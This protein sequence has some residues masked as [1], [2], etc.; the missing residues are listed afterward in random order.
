[1]AF[2]L[3]A[4]AI[5]AT[6][7][8]YAA[9]DLVLTF[10]KVGSTSTVYAD[11]GSAASFRGASAGTFAAD[12]INFLD[13][14][15]TLTSAFGADW[16]S[17]P[18]VFSSVSA[19]YSSSGTSNTVVDGDAS[20]TLYVS[21]TRNDIGTAGQAN[22]GTPSV[23]SNT[24]MTGA[25]SQILA[26]NAILGSN[27][28]GFGQT[29]SDTSVSLID[30]K[31]PIT[32][33][34]GSNIQGTAFG[35]FGG[36][37]AQAGSASNFG[38]LG[39]VS[40]VEFALDLY[41][42][43]AVNGKTNEVNGT[44]RSGDFQGTITLNSS[45]QVSFLGGATAPAVT[46]QPSAVTL[47]YG[48]TTTLS[49]VAT[50]N[51]LTYQWY[52]GASGDTSSPIAGAT[53]ASYTTS[54]LTAASNNFWVQATNALGTVDSNTAT[55]N[56]RPVLTGDL[57]LT[58]QKVGSTKTVYADLGSASSFRGTAN[59][60]NIADL[61]AVL[62]EAFGADWAIDPNVFSSVSGVYSSSGTSNT[63]V[64]GD[65]SRTLYVSANRNDV[66]SA[67]IANSG[68]P[69]V[70]SNTDMTGAASQILAQN[71]I[72]G[73]NYDVL[74]T[75][76]DTSISLIDDKQ[77]ITVFGGSNIQGTAFG[78]FGGGISQA[79]NAS[80]FGTLGVAGSVEFALD[81]YRI[82]AVNGKI[83]EVN[84]T[85]RSGDFQGTV[86]VD[87]SGIV[88]FIAAVVA[89]AVTAQPTAVTLNYSH[90]TTLS[91]AATGDSLTYQWYIGT[92]GDTSSPI[93]DAT[94]ASYTTSA[95]TA[96]TSFWVRT[97]NVAGSVDS[98]TATV[99]VRAPLTGDLMLTFQKVGSTKTV[100]ADLGSAS[101]F[102]GAANT[103][104]I[105]D[106][107]AVLIEAFG[108]DWASDPNVFSSV[109]GV[110]SSSSTSSTVVNGDASRTLYV[111]ATRND[112]GTAGQANS[113]TPTVGSNTDMT[114]AASQILAQ[115]AI[116]GSNY[117]VL[118]TVSDTSISLIDDKQPITVFGGSNIQGTAFGVFG[119]GIAQAGS[120]SS[121][122][123]LG[124]A[125]N[126]EFALDLYRIVAVNGK[127][128]EIN[129]TIR[130]GDF[131][132]TVT[133]NSSGIVSFVAAVAAPTDVIPAITTQPSSATINNGATTTL[134][135]EASG[136]SP[137]YQWYTGTS[138]DTTSPIGGATSASYTTSALTATTS[139]WVRA[140]NAA[141]DADSSAATVTVRSPY[142]SWMTAYPSIS[143]SASADP[144]KD[145]LSNLTE[146]AL[147][148]NPSVAGAS[149][150]PTAVISGSNLVVSFNRSADS[151]STTTAVVQYSTNLNTWT[152]VSTPTTGGA[153]TVNVPKSN[154]VSGKLFTRLKV[155]QP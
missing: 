87:N 75:V 143:Q 109:S 83:N 40:S 132:G 77:P 149:I 29:V 32:V 124:V 120:A 27:Y 57:M 150:A 125:S 78:V 152:D 151:V 67:G 37:I 155:T 18:N 98:S 95:L 108:A 117:D 81:L 70:G 25:A 63:V 54:A 136:T 17:D 89:P 42:I 34:G 43:V 72:L 53:S 26:Q 35:V 131:Q 39:A 106:I 51:S 111:S 145:G 105:A 41:R 115:N 88:S 137:T 47:N 14:N 6:P 121:F 49:V 73:S 110:Y 44:L 82:V 38:T 23:G 65:A 119:G 74:Q 24:D 10:Q 60:L 102:R 116:L 1:M 69:T 130:S 114:G 15:A 101:S 135:V 28:S 129:G 107:S 62:A 140:H 66:G 19:V 50:G 71:A 46:T 128:N 91:V 103:L 133:V 45:G 113:G 58:F 4:P 5:A 144:D 85:L 93:A 13:L 94:S 84:G 68:A 96:T 56:V 112:V 48:H 100:Y 21:S 31:Q 86:T 147:G 138:G 146:F 90:A 92:S 97:T 148:G 36:G 118:Q 76:S 123:T 55:V 11:L 12:Q 141:G 134:T 154:A 126:V 99:T 2:G 8:T 139:F 142:D 153:Q 9:G 30:D 16:A 64:N 79:G 3:V 80:S 61:S 22:S 33:F 127:T 7:T 20:R 104:N 59:K 122:G 52:N